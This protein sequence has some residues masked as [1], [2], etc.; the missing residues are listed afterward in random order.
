MTASCQDTSPEADVLRRH[1]PRLNRQAAKRLVVGADLKTQF[2]L[3]PRR[4][5][6]EFFLSALACEAEGD[7]E[8]EACFYFTTTEVTAICKNEP[9]M[10]ASAGEKG[11]QTKPLQF[12]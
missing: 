2:P 9:S 8:R 4:L 12:L 5:G 1:Q 6:G 3:A 7:A 10:G 11:G